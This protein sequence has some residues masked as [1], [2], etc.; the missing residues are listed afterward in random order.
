[1]RSLQV[2]IPGNFFVVVVLVVVLVVLVVVVV[3][4][5]ILKM[6]IHKRT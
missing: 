3:V 1:M 5:R 4:A 6:W 2:H